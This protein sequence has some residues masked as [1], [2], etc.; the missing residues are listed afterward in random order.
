V[1]MWCLWREWNAQSFEDV[2]TLVI[3]LWKIMF[4][5]FY[6]WIFAH[7]SL[8]ISSFVNFLNFCYSFA[9]D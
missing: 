5:T 2:E 3:E 7:H 6:T 8:L 4:N 9:S 1:L